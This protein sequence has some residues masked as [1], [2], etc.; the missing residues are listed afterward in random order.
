SGHQQIIL[1][2]ILTAEMVGHAINTAS[3]KRGSYRST[4]HVTI[5]LETIKHGSRMD[6]KERIFLEAVEKG[7]KPTVIRS[8]AGPNPVSVNCTDMLGRSAIQIA[9]DNENTELVELL[10]Q[11]NGV[12]IGDALLYAIREGVYKIVEMLIEHPSITR[13]MLGADWSKVRHEEESFDYSPDISPIILAAHCNQFEILQLLLLH[14]VHADS[15]RHSLLRINTYKAL[16]SPAWIS[17]TSPDPTL[18][19]FRLS[20]ELEHLAL[21][22]NEFKDSYMQLSNQC[23]KYACDLLEQC[24]SSEEVIAVLNKVSD[25]D[26]EDEEVDTDKLTLS[27]LKLALKYEQKQFV[28]HP[29]CQQLLTSIWYE[30]LPGWRKRNGVM[31]FLTCIGLIF[32]LPF[33]AVYYLIFPRSK[34]GQLLRSP[35]MKF[36]YHSSSFGVFLFLLTCA[37]TDIVTVSSQRE[38]LRGPPP[39]ELEC[40]IVLWVSGFVWSECKQ[41]WEEGMKAYIRQWWNWMDFIM[42]TL[43]LA[44]F[45]LR[46]VS[47]VQIESGRY[48]SRDMARRDWPR[49]DP[50]LISEGLFAIANV[51]SFARIIYLFQANQ[52]LG[53]L[54]ISLGCMLIDVA[55]FLFIFFLVLTSFACG[56]NQ[57]Y[58]YYR[59]SSANK[60]DVFFTIEITDS[61]SFTQTVAEIMFIAYHGMAIVLLLNMLIAMMSNSFQDI[62]NHADME[63]KFS[64]SKL[65]MGYFDEGSTL[66]SPFN[67][68]IS[69]KSIYYMFRA[70]HRIL[71]KLFCRNKKNTKRRKSSEGTIRSR[72]TVGPSDIDLFKTQESNHPF[73]DVIEVDP[74]TSRPTFSGEVITKADPHP[75]ALQYQEVMRRLICRYIHQTKKQHR[76]D[77]VNEDD[78]LEIKQDISSL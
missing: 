1:L 30:G 48:G 12:E 70:I 64:R 20:W 28:A 52:H 26:E 61:Q 67:L 3:G 68:I 29:H 47:Y 53:P 42:L 17:L 73:N 59:E 44:T 22:E 54:Q 5:P 13:E 56:L 8:L 60:E 36:L 35:F 15:L 76:Q 6:P 71:R 62:E 10:L 33:M 11:Q 43:Y 51:F 72:Q 66:P 75:D 32:L 63:W 69:P 4:A 2:P 40:L 14:G 7:D 19:A 9:V 38:S 16:A 23:K 65:W 39:T 37:S 45:S 24:R 58:W 78:L 21:R 57:L 41:L 46:I 74:V 55:K 77:G 31:K 34:I 25:S 49:N 18:T 27:R 50:T